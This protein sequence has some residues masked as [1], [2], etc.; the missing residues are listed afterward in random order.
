MKFK[1]LALSV[2]VFA[3]SQ[4]AF[5]DA[6]DVSTVCGT[7]ANACTSLTPVP[8]GMK[9]KGQSGQDINADAWAIQCTNDP[10]GP[11]GLLYGFNWE[12][13]TAGG[14]HYYILSPGGVASGTGK[15]YTSASDAVKSYCTAPLQPGPNN[16]TIPRPLL[17]TWYPPKT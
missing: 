7:A 13:G 9:T 10:T 17:N 4:A 8:D 6:P 15:N 14:Y 11:T 16:T 3:A 1:H 12:S 5:A 2:A